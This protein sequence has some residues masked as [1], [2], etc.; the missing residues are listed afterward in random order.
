M[1][2][3]SLLDKLVEVVIKNKIRRHIDECC[4][5]IAIHQHSLCRE[6]KNYKDNFLSLSTNNK[7]Q[8]LD[9]F[10]PLMAVFEKDLN[11]VFE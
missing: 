2:F 10:F 8:S 11:K 7:I 4:D 9:F 3:L 6:K 5:T 1:T